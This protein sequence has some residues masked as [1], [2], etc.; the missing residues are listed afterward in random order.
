MS[1]LQKK[2]SALKREHPALQK[3]KFINFFLCLLVIFAIWIHIHFRIWIG[4]K[5]EVRSGSRSNAKSLLL[6]SRIQGCG[7]AFIFI[8]IRIQH[9]RLNTDPDPGL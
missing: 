1:K 8:W 3:M 7:S 9:F 5:M 6:C 2:P 4:I